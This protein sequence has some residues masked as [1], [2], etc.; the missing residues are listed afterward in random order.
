MLLFFVL[1]MLYN[2]LIV[3][4]MF[5]ILPI[6]LIKVLYSYSTFVMLSKS[7]GYDTMIQ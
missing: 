5:Q 4:S 7:I 6:R 3:L 2:I 1:S